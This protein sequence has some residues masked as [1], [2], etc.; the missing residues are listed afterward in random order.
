MIDMVSRRLS[1]RPTGARLKN[2]LVLH[3]LKRHC[4]P[5]IG[6]FMRKAASKLGASRGDIAMADVAARQ[7]RA[8][9]IRA[10]EIILE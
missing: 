8:K 3:H 5:Q 2:S 6:F 4:S 9:Q 10:E 7:V 1:R